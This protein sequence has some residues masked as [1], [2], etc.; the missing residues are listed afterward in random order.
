MANMYTATTDI[1]TAAMGKTDNN[2]D[3]V[4]RANSNSNANE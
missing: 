1:Y 3:T 2:T 4:I